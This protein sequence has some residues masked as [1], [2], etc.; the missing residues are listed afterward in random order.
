[1]II[2]TG[3]ASLL[4]GSLGGAVGMGVVYPFD[5]LKTKPQVYGQLRRE[6]VVDSIC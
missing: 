3:A 4:A 1:M 2:G 5:T 6:G